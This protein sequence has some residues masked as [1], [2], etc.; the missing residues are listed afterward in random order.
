MGLTRPD[1]EKRIN[2]VNFL[3]VS[4]TGKQKEYLEHLDKIK[5]LDDSCTDLLNQLNE[6]SGFELIKP[7]VELPANF[8]PLGGKTISPSLK[9]HNEEVIKYSI[10]SIGSLAAFGVTFKATAGITKPVSNAIRI[11]ALANLL[12][13]VGPRQAFHF[14][15]AEVAAATKAIPFQTKLRIAGPRGVLRY[16]G[17]FGVSTAAS[18]AVFFGIDIGIQAIFDE[19]QYAELKK[20][21]VRNVKFRYEICAHLKFISSY[22]VWLE[23]LEG[24]L[25]IYISMYKNYETIS[26]DNVASIKDILSDSIQEY[27]KIKSNITAKSIADYLEE[28]DKNNESYTNNDPSESKYCLEIFDEVKNQLDIHSLKSIRIFHGD[29]VDAVQCKATYSEFHEKFGGDGGE[30]TTIDLKEG[31]EIIEM[32]WDSGMYFG[33]ETVSNLII[34]T[35]H[36][37]KGYGPFGTG[38]YVSRITPKGV[39]VPADW[40]VVDI[41]GQIV[42]LEN[43]EKESQYLKSINLIGVEKTNVVGFEN[44]TS[45]STVPM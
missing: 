35:T 45:R 26:L 19:K 33:Q 36:C 39:S 2:R 3:S 37:K 23:K 7:T 16:V 34:K 41:T 1:N 10:A 27:N 6:K 22:S 14:S 13:D 42:D 31:E 24:L 8:I 38:E 28:E 12:S 29:V 25:K 40:I 17:R 30:M 9:K 21:I 43:I 44:E 4:C 32:S 18:T 11:R 20:Q 15:Q 5:K